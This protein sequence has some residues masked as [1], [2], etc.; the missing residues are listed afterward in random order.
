M[1]NELNDVLRVTAE[2]DPANAGSQ[3]QNVYYYRIDGL[4]SGD[5][6]DIIDDFEAEIATLMGLVE[7]YFSTAYN[8]VSVRVSNVTKR[9]RIGV[10]ALA[11]SGLD[12]TTDELPS[13]IAALCLFPLKELGKTGRKYL[14]PPT[15]VCQQNSALVAGAITSFN[16]YAQRL[17]TTVTGG[18]SGNDYNAG[19]ARFTGTTLDSFSEF[20][21]G[22]QR[23]VPELRTQRRRTPGVGLS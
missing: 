22:T 9:E 15:E 8:G 4:V 11:W 16:A 23:T 2:F 6:A 18:T 7:D 3:V 14:G 10:G 5:D 19:I 1:A 13:Q 17:T 21:T 20:L 12:A